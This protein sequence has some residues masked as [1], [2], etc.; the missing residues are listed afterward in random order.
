MTT[1]V[2]EHVVVT[3]NI[4]SLSVEQAN[5]GTPL[6]LDYFSDS[7]FSERVRSFSG[8]TIL[9][10][11]LALGF[12]AASPVYLMAQ[13]VVS[14]SPKVE[15]IKVGRLALAYTQNQEVEVTSN[16][17]GDSVGLTI[18]DVD[19]TEYVASYTVVAL[20]TLNDVAIALKAAI[21]AHGLDITIA[22]PGAA[23]LQ[24]VADNA[25]DLFYFH[26]TS[27]V[28][29]LDD[30][31]DPG[32]ATDMA[33]IA[34]E[35]DDWY[36][37][38]HALN[39]F[40][41]V[42]ALATWTETQRKIFYAQTSDSEVP[43]SG[44][45]DIATEL[46]D[47]AR[48]RTAIVYHNAL[49]GPLSE[50]PAAAIPG[51]EFTKDPGSYTMCFKTLSGVSP[52]TLTEDNKAQLLDKLCNMYLRI[53][54]VNILRWGTVSVT[55]TEGYLDTRRLIDWLQ[56]RIEENIFRELAG[57]DKLP[58][59]DAGID[60]IRAAIY[61]VWEQAAANDAAVLESFQFSAT[62]AADQAEQDRIDRIIRG[63]QV[64][65]IITPGVHKVYVE[66]NI[67]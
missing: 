61:E 20:D 39:S 28:T 30:T 45:G 44:T 13:A 57:S 62:A 9:T 5:F 11:L 14:Q 27:N 37:I 54:G 4:D 32:I 3:I 25:G 58:Y 18:V 23:E 67:Q 52:N 60:Q 40:A 48:T 6:L 2:Q 31:P 17:E 12:T 34:L 55:G 51:V 16:T 38:V 21:D 41:I 26:T 24:L 36:G 8:R 49:D 19:G 42:D 10:E 7:I 1:S 53:A 50:Y 15:T 35:D 43:T 47:D 46:K 29:L 64:G 59:D 66:F 63:I 22:A 33:A 56:A 65:G